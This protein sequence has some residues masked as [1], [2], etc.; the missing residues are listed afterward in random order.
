M[1]TELS[2]VLSSLRASGVDKEALYEVESAMSDVFTEN[3]NLKKDMAKIK[4]IAD[5]NV[6]EL[7]TYLHDENKLKY[8]KTWGEYFTV[9]TLEDSIGLDYT[10]PRRAYE[11]AL[12]GEEF[13]HIW[14]E[15]MS[16]HFYE[17]KVKNT[18]SSFSRESK[19]EFTNKV[20]MRMI[21]NFMNR[22]DVNMKGAII[23]MD[24]FP[25]FPMVALKKF[26]DEFKADLLSGKYS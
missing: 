4:M 19:F 9:M 11:D 5:R 21:I 26:F 13:F 24:T 8:N 20:M 18:F 15:D 12:S 3:D 10:D 7:S 25:K 6:S 14:R 23:G 17:S 1:S 16:L 2:K 22:K